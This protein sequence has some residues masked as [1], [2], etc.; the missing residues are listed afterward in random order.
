MLSALLGP[1]AQRRRLLKKAPAGA[2][3]E[4]LATPF[5]DR[6]SDIYSVPIV[7]VDFET[8]GLD[9]KTD[10]ILSIGHVDL[11]GGEILLGSAAHTIIQPD[12]SLSEESV[13]I[14]RITDDEAAFGKPLE[15]SIAA[16]LE[17]LAGKVM[18]AHH[19]AIE[20]GFLQQVCRQVYGLAPVVPVID[21]LSLARKWLARRNKEV[22]QGA[23]R[24]YALRERY[25]LPR[26]N[27]HN[28]LSDALA[29]AE[30]FLA[31]VEHMDSSKPPTLGNLLS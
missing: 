28:A 8:T 12:T 19:A 21:T 4:Y 22:E 30:L 24:L 26:Y 31:Q 18:L 10:R 7:S 25:D 20:R 2:M 29:T 6:R 13:V 23:L 3:R 16:L 11:S 14:H 17:A 1:D 15:T 27:A 9:S 5:P